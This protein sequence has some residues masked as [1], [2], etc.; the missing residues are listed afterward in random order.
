LSENAHRERH[1]GRWLLLVPAVIV[2]ALVV[3]GVDPSADRAKLFFLDASRARLIA[4][5]RA[6]PL[7]GSIE[8]RSERVLKELLLGPFDNRLQPLFLQDARIAVVMHRGGRLLVELEIPELSRVDIPFTLLRSSMERTLA[9]SV[10]G[11]GRLELYIN[12]GL[13]FSR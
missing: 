6:M 2:L 13:A 10:P 9:A 12:G 8:E 7:V 1:S 5:R 11:Y 3:N 4:E